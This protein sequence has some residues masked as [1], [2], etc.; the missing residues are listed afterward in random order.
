M[1][2]TFSSPLQLLIPQIVAPLNLAVIFQIN[3]ALTIPVPTPTVSLVLSEASE[4][5]CT[6]VARLGLH[7][8]QSWRSFSSRAC[9]PSISLRQHSAL[10]GDM[11][12]TW[13]PSYSS[14]KLLTACYN[15][16][17][18]RT[19][20]FSHLQLESQVLTSSGGIKIASISKSCFIY[21]P[22]YSR[23]LLRSS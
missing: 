3:K 23:V 5:A 7:M 11:D 4:M 19:Y 6:T 17:L 1:I 10:R 2:A 22:A 21:C 16:Y 18:R 15:S 12:A 14:I 8:R 13:A 20:L 9:L